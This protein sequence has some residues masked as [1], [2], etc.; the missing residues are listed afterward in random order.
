MIIFWKN[1]A[2]VSNRIILIENP[3]AIF[4]RIIIILKNP[5]WVSCGII[6]I[7]KNPALVSLHII[8]LGAESIDRY[9]RKAMIK[10]CK[11]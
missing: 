6:I 4:R 11:S 8:T 1:T 3:V 5:V 9:Y 2:M 7:W 10:H